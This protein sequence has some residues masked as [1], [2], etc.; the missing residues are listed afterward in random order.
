[1]K[2]FHG[3]FVV[4]SAA[5]LLLAACG[6]TSAAQPASNLPTSI[7]AGEGALNLVA[8]TGYVESGKTDPKVDWVTPFTNQTGCKINVKF[9][10]GCVVEYKAP[11]FVAVEPGHQGWVVGDEPAVL[12]EFDFE[13]ETVERLGVPV[14]KHG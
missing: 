9:A 5:V 3:N 14:H 10:D 4:A 12:I 11:Q 7:G 13:G 8:W 2:G 6:G 1:M